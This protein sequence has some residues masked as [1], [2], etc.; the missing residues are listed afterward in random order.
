MFKYGKTAQHAV[1]VASYLAE[2]YDSGH[3]RFSS[4]QI[5]QQRKLPKP[6][7]AKVLSVL[8]SSGLVAGTPGPGGGYWLS[9]SPQEIRL[10]DIVA[11]FEKEERR[12]GCPFGP[13]WCESGPHC[14]LHDDIIALDVQLY[15]FLHN[16]RLNVFSPSTNPPPSTS[17][18]QSS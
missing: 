6:I 10:V 3:S 5:A 4:L 7:V 15:D 2:R 11:C 16:T 14:P 9:R 1:A 18:L 13:H 8:S 17:N 12:I